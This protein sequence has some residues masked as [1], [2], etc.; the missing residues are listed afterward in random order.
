M[1]IAVASLTAMG[2]M[3]Q[4]MN[5][6]SRIYWPKASEITAIPA[7]LQDTQTKG[8]NTDRQLSSGS[9]GRGQSVDLF[10]GD[11]KTFVIL[12]GELVCDFEKNTKT[13]SVN[14]R[15]VNICFPV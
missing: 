7:G 3:W 13:F 10:L 15:L 1:P 2:G 11:L 6:G 5:S 12:V 4:G 14:L 8:R 9:L